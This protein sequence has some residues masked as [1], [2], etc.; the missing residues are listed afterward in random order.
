MDNASNINY[1]NFSN[2]NYQ[3]LSDKPDNQTITT[4]PSKANDEAKDKN[5]K[6]ALVVLS[7]AI[8]AVALGGLL[9]KHSADIK[10]AQKFF[11]KFVNQTQ[12]NN[13]ILNEALEQS[14]SE[15]EEFL[16]KHSDIHTKMLEYIKGIVNPKELSQIT[17]D[18]IVYHGTSIKTAKSI[19]QNGITPF[20]SKAGG[21]DLPGLGRG[22]YTTPTYD[23]AKLYSGKGIVLPYRLEGEIGELSPDVDLDKL[24]AEILTYISDGLEPNA[25]SVK[26]GNFDFG[27]NYSEQTQSKA[28]SLSAN[29]M[30]TL[31]RECG[32]SGVY[33]K[34][35][36]T[37]G[38]GLFG[39]SIPENINID[40]AGQLAVFDGTKLTLDVEKLKELNP[41]G[42]DNYSLFR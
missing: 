41:I 6:K 39:N 13:R 12:G 17:Q 18:N 22:V 20:A 8:G 32:Y 34:E 19:F 5:V 4:N 7:A 27:K 30:N 38:F 23:L 25:Q 15:A 33:T 3:N 42:K 21:N 37:G 10:D 29:I 36:I 14:A 35:G 31:F 1:K 40:T 16:N 28:E 2:F 26:I 9:V 11:D 24:R